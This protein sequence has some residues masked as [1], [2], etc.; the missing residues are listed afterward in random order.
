MKRILI[1]AFVLSALLLASCGATAATPTTSD[2]YVSPNLP[3]DYENAMPV[4]NQLAIGAMKLDGTANAL[5]R[6]QAA[7]LL[8][9]YQALQGTSVSGGG[10]QAEI[11][12]LLSQIEATM[13]P[14]QLSAIREMK[15]TTADMQTWAAENGVTLGQGGGQPGSGAGMSPEARATKQAAEGVTGKTPGS[16]GAAAVMETMINYL[17]KLAQ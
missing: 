7:K 12:A 5:T 11:S 14:A 1:F 8:P 3:A 17:K 4:R 2:V 15:L 13:T 16:S 9:L 10:S 6:E